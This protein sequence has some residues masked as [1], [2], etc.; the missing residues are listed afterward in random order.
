MTILKGS[1]RLSYFGVCYCNVNGGNG[2]ILKLR[3]E[4]ICRLRSAA[5]N[6][7][8]EDVLTFTSVFGTKIN[9]LN[10]N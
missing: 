2:K 9:L 3:G 10:I 4:D 8:F 5:A 1:N 7:P 6:L